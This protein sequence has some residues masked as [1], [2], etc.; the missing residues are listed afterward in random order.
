MT[1][2]VPPCDSDVQ[3][4]VTEKYDLLAHSYDEARRGPF[5]G[6]ASDALRAMVGS[7][8]GLRILDVPVGTGRAMSV[9]VRGSVQPESYVGVDIAPDMITEAE[10]KARNLSI[11]TYRRVQASL[12]GPA[13]AFR[14]L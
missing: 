2:A 12:R 3:A 13:V 7:A 1:P 11:A 6:L 10:R 14:T 8:D 5:F 4:R 9:L